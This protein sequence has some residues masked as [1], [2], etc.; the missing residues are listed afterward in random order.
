MN[1]ASAEKF[2]WGTDNPILEAVMPVKQWLE[3]IR[4]LPE[5]APDG[6]IFTKEEIDLLVGGNAEKVLAAIPK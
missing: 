1:E 6:L 2:M 3:M 4:N 5:N